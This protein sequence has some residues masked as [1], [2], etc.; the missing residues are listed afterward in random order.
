MTVLLEQDYKVLVQ[1]PKILVLSTKLNLN[2]FH[3]A[4]FGFEVA[5]QEDNTRSLNLAA[6]F[7]FEPYKKINDIIFLTKTVR[8]GELQVRQYTKIP[9]I[10]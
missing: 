7:D 6:R 3:Y 9:L 1:T 4:P 8:Y 2:L 10:Q 5:T